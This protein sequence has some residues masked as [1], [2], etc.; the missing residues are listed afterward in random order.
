MG[1]EHVVGGLLFSTSRLTLFSVL[2]QLSIQ[3]TNWGRFYG[4]IILHYIQY[5]PVFVNNQLTFLWDNLQS[6]LLV[7]SLVHNDKVCDKSRKYFFRFMNQR[8]HPSWWWSHDCR[9]MKQLIILHPQSQSC[10]SAWDDG[11][12][13][14]CFFL[15]PQLNCSELCSWIYFLDDSR[16]RQDDNQ[17]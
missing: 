5:I 12:H 2:I 14:S 8:C 6:V 9:N 11:T 16:S 1:S 3:L 7:T 10:D 15:L 17:C 13:R 4:T